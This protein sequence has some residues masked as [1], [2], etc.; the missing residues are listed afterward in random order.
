[1]IFRILFNYITGFVNITVE[2]F[3]IERFINNCINNNIFLWKV[4]RKSST[5]L[6]ANISIKEFKKLHSISNKS[7]CRIKLN[8]K[9]GFPIKAHKYRNRKAFLIVI[10]PIVIGII[11][12]SQFI[13]NIEIVCTD[14]INKDEIIQGLKE[15]GIEIGKNKSKIDTKR[16]INNIRLSRND[17]S[18]MSID[19]KGT[20]IIVNIVKSTEKPDIL[21]E[22]I[23]CNIVSNKKALITKITA[24][25]GMA[26]VKVGDIVESGNI[27]IAGVMEGK[28]TGTR[29]VHA[30]G[31]IEGKV[32][33]TKKIESRNL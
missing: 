9:H 13:W 11:T 32:W 4:K 33:Y 28:Y 20:N 2:G 19:S 30:K 8:S 18:W 15:N 17:I 26:K 29:N 24:D 22:S 31:K 10:I 23:N 14:D 27:L 6:N 12:M 21:D 1:M 25:N 7:K 3:F 5:V 16:A